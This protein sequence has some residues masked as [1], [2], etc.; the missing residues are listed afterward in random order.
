MA[1]FGW[2]ITGHHD[3]CFKKT[4]LNVCSCECHMIHPPEAF[5]DKSNGE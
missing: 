4:D 5:R 3:Q 1:K 2:C